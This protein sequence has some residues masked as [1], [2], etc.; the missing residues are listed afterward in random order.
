M[1]VS[2]KVFRGIGASVVSDRPG[3][4]GGS[5]ES[6]GGV[7]GSISKGLKIPVSDPNGPNLN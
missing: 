5:G 7:G 2:L 4:F 1:A 3:V 6:D